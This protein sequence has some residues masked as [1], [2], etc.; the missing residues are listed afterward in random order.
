MPE[1]IED[2]QQ[3]AWEPLIAVADAAGGH[4]PE[5]ARAACLDLCG[6]ADDTDDDGI[7]LLAD[8]ED[9]FAAVTDPF[10]RSTQLVRELKDRDESPWRDNELTPHKL[11][12]MLKDYGVRPRPGPGYTAR[13]YWR[14]DFKDSFARYTV[15][16]RR[17]RRETAP[18]QSE[19][20]ENR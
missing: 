17:N 3:D 2:R 6:Q 9:I 8:I 5:L 7:Q 4:W 12:R 14:A 11:A 1:S 19:Q 13:G 10:L 15:A 20:G 16:N 18:D